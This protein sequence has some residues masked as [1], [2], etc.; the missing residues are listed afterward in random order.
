MNP[1]VSQNGC[2]TSYKLSSLTFL[3]SWLLFGTRAQPQSS[4]SSPR[5]HAC[6]TANDTDAD[7]M[8][9]MNALSLPSEWQALCIIHSTYRLVETNMW[10]LQSLFLQGLSE[11][12][13]LFPSMPEGLVFWIMIQTPFHKTSTILCTLNVCKVTQDHHIS[14]LSVA[15]WPPG[16]TDEHK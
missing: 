16:M 10:L 6:V 3:E 1:S 4:L 7:R 15:R 5:E 8:A 13:G 12:E 2:S 11:G 14:T 9:F